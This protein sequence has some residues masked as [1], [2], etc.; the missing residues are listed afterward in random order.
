M[1]KKPTIA[2]KSRFGNPVKAAADAA[3]RANVLSLADV[4]LDRAMEALSPGFVL[5][6]EAQ[7]R[8][9]E[10]VDIALMI[11]DDFFD[12][13]RL[14]EP[15]TNAMALVPEAV[16]EV[17]EVSADVNPQAT[18]AVR[19][20]V[21]D[22][23]D[24]LLAASLWTGTLQDVSALQEVLKQPNWP[25]WNSDAQL[26]L[27]ALAP[28]HDVTG[29]GSGSDSDSDSDHSDFDPAASEFLDVYI[30]ELSAELL[31]ATV[32]DSPLW[33]NMVCLLI[34]VGDGRAVTGKGSLQKK[35]HAEAAATL[36]H[37]G[38]RTL[39]AAFHSSASEGELEAE[40]INRLKLYWHLLSSSGLIQFKSA[41]VKLSPR[42]KECLATPEPMV[43][44]FRDALS[45]FIFI[46]TLTGSEPGY[47]EPWNINMSS[48]LTRCAS[49]SQPESAFLAAALEAP[50]TADPEVFILAK[51]VASWAAEGLVTVG[52]HLSVPPAFR[53]D[54]VEVLH[55]DFNIKAVGP[56]A[57][58]NVATLLTH[59]R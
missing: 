34:W 47:Y 11:L 28:N 52:E 18:F 44:E 6:L 46:S 2:K 31:R 12:M 39:E 22:Y 7:G 37:T 4:R 38:A 1:A 16:Q 20:G 58:T 35:D 49:V 9:E 32:A 56:G 33:Q 13:Y 54:L 21:R 30:P 55:A 26:K 5:W 24:Y 17:L 29:T 43:E 27:D 53:P 51:N 8:S 23:V 25:G 36:V 41:R 15:A 10:S 59:T 40:T 48:F 14:L 57:D 45:R 19:S 50:D 3:E 42:A